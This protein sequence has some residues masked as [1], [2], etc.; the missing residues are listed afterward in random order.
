ME[1]WRRALEKEEKGPGRMGKA[2]YLQNCRMGKKAMTSHFLW[3]NKC[4]D[5]LVRIILG[6]NVIVH[7]FFSFNN[8]FIFLCYILQRFGVCSIW[9]TLCLLFYSHHF[10]YKSSSARMIPWDCQWFVKKL[11]SDNYLSTGLAG[12]LIWRIYFSL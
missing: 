5:S 9:C 3:D 10:W 7:D 4:L 6:E 12:H 1:K 8:M 2:P 11:A